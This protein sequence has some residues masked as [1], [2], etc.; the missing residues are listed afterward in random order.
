MFA[1]RILLAAA[2]VVNTTGTACGGPPPPGASSATATST[3]MVDIGGGLQGR[4]GLEAEVLATGLT[5]V[6]ALAFDRD[7]RLWASTAKFNDDGTDAVHL[8][9]AD[10]DA[11]ADG[12]GAA[13]GV[14]AELHTPLGL[15]WVDDELFVA[16]AGR[17]D[18]Y[19]GLD[20]TSFSA[21]RSVVTFDDGVG[22][23]NGMAQT[24]DG[25]I[26]LGISAPCDACEP[27]DDH[28]ASI[29]SFSPDGTDLRPYATEIRAP[30]GLAFFPGTDV[31]FVTMNQQ[32]QLGDSTPGDWL[33]VVTEGQSWGFPDCC[34]QGGS[35]C[36]N[37]PTPVAELDVHAAVSGVGIVADQLGEGLGTAAV[38]A[39]WAK[40]QLV[41]VPLDPP[42]FT[43]P[44]TMTVLATGFANPVPVVVGPDGALCVGD[45]GNGN[46]FRIGNAA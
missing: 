24:P 13:I 38:V 22:E 14:I 20:G 11:D 42:D 31:L 27:D 43:S 41:S 21:S 16:S 9:D 3:P 12:A 32:D 39:E 26:L 17:V 18:A 40:S 19:G 1:R 35:S 6:A 28:S 23:L 5:N 4:F 2:L 8:I 33:A 30:I 7:D 34:G 36:K 46:V 25:R 44:E 37:R 15:L 45:W 29:V 10:A